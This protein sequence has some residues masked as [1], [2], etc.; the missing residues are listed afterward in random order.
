MKYNIHIYIER[1]IKREEKERRQKL[2][3]RERELTTQ[4][5][6]AHAQEREDM[7]KKDN[8]GRESMRERRN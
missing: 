8:R 4:V 7:R 3:R 5:V 1:E 2:K 6:V